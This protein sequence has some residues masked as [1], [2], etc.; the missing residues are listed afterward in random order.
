MSEDYIGIDF[1]TTNTA[2]VR[3]R[4]DELGQKVDLLG[5]DGKYPF[6]SIVA[7]P[8]DGSNEL[9]FGR[10]VREKRL[11]LSETHDIHLSMKTFLDTKK[12]FIIGG[13]R[14]SA[15]DITT[16]FLEYVK[17][18]ILQYHKVDI[19]KATFSFPVDF[20]PEARRELKKAAK[21]AGIEPLGFVNESTAAYLANQ[22]EGQ[23]FSTVMVVDWGGGTLDIS[24]MKV[25]QNKLEEHSIWGE[26]IGGDDIDLALAKGI[27]ASIIRN[28][29]TKIPFDQM[30]SLAADDLR[31]RCEKAKME[32]STYQDDYL[33][34]LSNYGIYGIKN[35]NLRYDFFEHIAT[36]IIKEKVFSTIETALQKANLT[37]HNIDAVILVGGSS[38]ITPF[39][40]AMCETFEVDKIIVPEN[41]QWSVATGAAF[42]GSFK[43]SF[44]LNT[45]LSVLLS[46]DTPFPLFEKER[47]TIGSSLASMTFDLTEDCQE[48][49]FIFV[50]ENKNVFARHTVPTK[51]Y[52]KEKITL[53]GHITD[54]QIAYLTLKSTAT[55]DTNEYTRHVEINK[56]KFY[57]DTAPHPQ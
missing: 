25:S 27:H 13:I 8:R 16:K 39:E 43:G 44:H 35:L 20:S 55:G 17:K 10:A 45:T 42:A 2:V 37:S 40:T 36:P 12:E 33:L 14:Y 18:D 41:K 57:Y 6:S 46:D 56:L 19:T 30:P 23:A 22:K 49:H 7:I 53:E 9:L 4:K 32:F 15:T 47:D 38:N 3:L 24:I 51:G 50:D 48:A 34:T 1:G 28:Q 52:L 54:E 26:R 29:E 5:D 11:A 31:N 21:S